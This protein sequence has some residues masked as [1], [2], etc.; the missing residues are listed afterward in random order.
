MVG[1][2]EKALFLRNEGDEVFPDLAVVRSVHHDN[3]PTHEQGTERPGRLGDTLPEQKSAV[4]E[5]DW[6]RLEKHRF[7]RE[8]A[9]RLYKAA[10]R[11]EYENLIIVAPPVVLGELR[12][13]LHKE[14]EERV[15]FDVAKELTKHPVDEIEKSICDL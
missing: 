15:L 14:V 9:E 13:A 5:T 3:P 6:H 11:G 1:D 7:A 2:G 8:I 10:H 12:K 4:Q